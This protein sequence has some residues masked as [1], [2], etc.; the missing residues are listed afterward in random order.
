MPMQGLGFAAVRAETA[1]LSLL[2]LD[3]PPVTTPKQPHHRRRTTTTISFL[4]SPP[5]HTLSTRRITKDEQRQTR[6]YHRRATPN[7]TLPPPMHPTISSLSQN[8]LRINELNALTKFYRP[9]SDIYDARRASSA[10]AR[11]IVKALGF[12]T[13]EATFDEMHCELF[14]IGCCVYSAY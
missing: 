7:Q 8:S 9:S 12:C 14:E 6:P 13:R 4:L 10:A 5:S 3:A 1:S 2:Y 11:N